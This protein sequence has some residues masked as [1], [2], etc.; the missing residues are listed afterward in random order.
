MLY[1]WIYHGHPRH[2]LILPAHCREIW[3]GVFRFYLQQNL[4]PVER[5]LC[6]C[7]HRLRDSGTCPASPL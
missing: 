5:G 6:R 3:E 7:C 1:D 4:L 2:E